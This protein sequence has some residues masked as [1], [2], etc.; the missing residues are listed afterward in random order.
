MGSESMSTESHD[1]ETGGVGMAGLMPKNASILR[2][3]IRILRLIRNSTILGLMGSTGSSANTEHFWRKVL[4]G[5]PWRCLISVELCRTDWR[6]CPQFRITHRFIRYFAGTLAIR[7]CCLPIGLPW[8]RACRCQRN[9]ERV[10]LDAFSC[11]HISA[12]SSASICG[13]RRPAILE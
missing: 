10:D 8:H 1:S 2:I 13:I 9:Q 5:P 7:I 4:H 11:W 3:L 6:F 12:S